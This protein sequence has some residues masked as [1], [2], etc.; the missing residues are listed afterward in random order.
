M[1]ITTEEV[2][3]AINNTQT[4]ITEFKEDLEVNL[5]NVVDATISNISLAINETAEM[6]SD[7][8]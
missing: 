6:A 7:A 2:G 8:F 3:I 5:E 4:N 1:N